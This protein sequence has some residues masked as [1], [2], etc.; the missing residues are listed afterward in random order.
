ME[1]GIDLFDCLN[2][3]VADFCVTQVDVR[4]LLFA[5]TACL[6]RFDMNVVGSLAVLK[7]LSISVEALI[8]SGLFTFVELRLRVSSVVLSSVT[9]RSESSI[10][11]LTLEGSLASVHPFMHLEI[12]LVSEL[13]P[14]HVLLAYQEK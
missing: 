14:T 13:F 3:N 7:E 10:A 1:N 9:A 8:T 6:F 5:A 4:V 2:W 12:R 11:K